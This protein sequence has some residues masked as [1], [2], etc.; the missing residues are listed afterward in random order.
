MAEEELDI[1]KE[2]EKYFTESTG[3][4]RDKLK[5]FIDIV[6]K[7]LKQ[8]GERIEELEKENAELKLS[9]KIQVDTAFQMIYEKDEKQLT[10]AKEIIKDL[11][12][13]SKEHWLYSDIKKQAEQFLKENDRRDLDEI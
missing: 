1:R 9:C 4:G 3:F 11:L 12:E 7:A 5:N 10:K 8:K 2:I 13:Y 6:N